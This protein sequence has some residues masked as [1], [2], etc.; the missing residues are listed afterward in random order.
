MNCEAQIVVGLDLDI[1]RER[2]YACTVKPISEQE[3]PN[4]D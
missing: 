3:N 2:F 4:R 1:I